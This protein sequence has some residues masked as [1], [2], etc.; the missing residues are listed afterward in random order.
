MKPDKLDPDGALR[1]RAFMVDI[2]PT[3]VEVY[4]FMRKIVNHIPIEGGIHLDEKE[5][6]KVVDLL[7]KGSSKQSANLRKLSRGLNMFAGSLKA[8]IKV[9]DDEMARMI[10]MYA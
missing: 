2:N 8:G 6:L 10:S 9:N 7:E 3:D 4:E 1:T 5:R